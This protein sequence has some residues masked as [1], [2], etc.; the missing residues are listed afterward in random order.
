M[1]TS[2][3]VLNESSLR[4]KFAAMTTHNF[5]LAIIGSMTVCRRTQFFRCLRKRKV[6]T[7]NPQNGRTYELPPFQP[8]D[9]DRVI[10]CV[11]F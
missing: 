7:T 2:A 5:N 4:D 6:T 11:N 1:P 9:S 8:F 10:F 3:D